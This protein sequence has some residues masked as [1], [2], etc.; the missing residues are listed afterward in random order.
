[1]STANTESLPSQTTKSVFPPADSFISTGVK[2]AG[3]VGAA[4]CGLIGAAISEE[5]GKMQNAK[6]KRQK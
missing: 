4:D 1:V 3:S 2:Y 6:G 5:Q